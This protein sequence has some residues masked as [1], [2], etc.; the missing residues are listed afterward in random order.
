MFT[1]SALSTLLLI[2]TTVLE[3]TQAD[4]CGAG[5]PG[6]HQQ[7]QI[8]YQSSS[9][10]CDIELLIEAGSEGCTDKTYYWWSISYTDVDGVAHD[11][12]SLNTA[13]YTG[14]DDSIF[15]NYFPIPFSS[16]KNGE[17]IVATITYSGDAGEAAF[18]VTWTQEPSVVTSNTVATTTVTDTTDVSSSKSEPS[19]TTVCS[20]KQQYFHFPS[21][22]ARFIWTYADSS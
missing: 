22:C 21:F 19:P 6:F 17:P 11:V 12:P 5:L 16:I 10:T 15:T 13:T 1:L 18:P 8:A 20:L 7:G 4:T 2:L 9:D 14:P 3:P